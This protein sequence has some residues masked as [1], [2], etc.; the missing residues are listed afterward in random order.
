MNLGTYVWSLGTSDKAN[1]WTYK[2][3]SSPAVA[4]VFDS[5]L[6]LALAFYSCVS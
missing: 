4:A 2:L 5:V 6:V 3:L 1:I